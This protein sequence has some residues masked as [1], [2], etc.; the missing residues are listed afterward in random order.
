MPA[1]TAYPAP[2]SESAPAP[3]SAE[4]G[5]SAREASPQLV[6]SRIPMMWL[7]AIGGI[8]AMWF[9]FTRSKKE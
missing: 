9:Y 4:S 1:Q 3:Q 6:A 7:F 2:A 8:A 5:A